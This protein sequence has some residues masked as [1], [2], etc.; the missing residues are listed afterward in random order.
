[1]PVRI[2][3]GRRLRMRWMKIEAVIHPVRLEAITATLNDLAIEG[4]VMSHVLSHDG[5]QGLKAFY[6]GSEYLVD[7]PRVKL[8]ML[9]S[10]LQVDE[11]IDAL[12]LAACTGLS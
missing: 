1:M 8:E 2:L 7:T 9:V 12:A 11:V 4:I 3:S 10:S 6:R 5:P